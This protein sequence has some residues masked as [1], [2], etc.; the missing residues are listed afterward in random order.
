MLDSDLALLY[1]VKTKNLNKAVDRNADRFP[2]DF[3]FQLNENEAKSSRFQIGTL[4]RGQNIKY[5]PYV[6][7][8]QGVTMLSCVL[9]SK[10]AVEVNIQI[11]RTFVKLREMIISNKGLRIKMENMER[12][13]DKRFK[14]IFDTL[15]SLIDNNKKEI[16]IEEKETIGFKNRKNK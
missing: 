8:E 15:R 14:V 4:K 11:I 1:D 5:L 3:M 12:K 10:R 6:F 7:T 2:G 9:R 16:S 13:Y